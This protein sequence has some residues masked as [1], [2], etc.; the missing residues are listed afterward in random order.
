MADVQRV[1][2]TT[3]GLQGLFDALHRRGYRL[4]GPTLRDGAILY[5]DIAGIAD[6]PRGWTDEQDGGRYR[7]HRRGDDALF[8][9]AVGPHSWKR[10]LHPAHRRLWSAQRSGAGVTVTP[11]P[12]ASDRFA[13]IGVRACD[14]N[15]I[16]IQD[17]VLTG[18]PWV[19][20]SY[21]ARRRGAFILAINCGVAGGTCFCVS[22]QSGPRADRGYDLALTELAGGSEHC[23]VIHGGSDEGLTVLAEVPH[24]PATAEEMTQAEAIVAGT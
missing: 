6:L 10:F 12:P 21:R 23:F 17:R 3:D 9:Y 4:V 8:G 16:A 18:G 13:F 22:M 7:V 19:D 5:D 11:E 15:A 1:T 2:M 14:L 20:T 24:R